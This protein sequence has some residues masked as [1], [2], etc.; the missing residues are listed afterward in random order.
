MLQDNGHALVFPQYI[1][2][3]ILFKRDHSLTIRRSRG[4]YH[5][6]FD[7]LAAFN[8][9]RDAVRTISSPAPEPQDAQGKVRYQSS[10][11]EPTSPTPPVHPSTGRSVDPPTPLPPPPTDPIITPIPTPVLLAST[12]PDSFA[13]TTPA[14]A[15]TTMTYDE[16]HANSGI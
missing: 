4:G 5:V 6:T 13:S 11:A 3:C 8:I 9:S 14:S 1:N 16:F 12:T 10:P 7:Q 2:Q 15:I